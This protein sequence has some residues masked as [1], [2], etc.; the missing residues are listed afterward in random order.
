MTVRELIG[1]AG[2]FTERDLTRAFAEGVEPEAALIEDWMAP[3]PDSLGPEM[4]VETAGSWT[5]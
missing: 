3:F 4:S 5:R 1:E 2:I